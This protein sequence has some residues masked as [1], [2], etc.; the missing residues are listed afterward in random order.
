MNTHKNHFGRKYSDCDLTGRIMTG[1]VLDCWIENGGAPQDLLKGE[2]HFIKTGGKIRTGLVKLKTDN[3]SISKFDLFVK[4]YRVKKP[5]HMINILLGRNR[6]PNVWNISW[7]LISHGVPVP[8]PFGYFGHRLGKQWGTSYFCSEVLPDCIPLKFIAVDQRSLFDDLL[9]SGFLKKLADGVASLHRTGATHGDLKWTNI[10]VKTNNKKF[11]FIDLDASWRHQQFRNTYYIA[12]D[13]ARF[14]LGARE[15]G[16][17]QAEID[18]FLNRYGELRS[19]SHSYLSRII[20][21][22]IEKITGKKNTA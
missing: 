5:M 21:S 1:S 8:R 14:V 20:E 18:S 9:S 17:S 11:W 2:V 22:R 4:E 7:F 6:A 16:L 13:L 12:R 3:G 15:V 10:L 19:L